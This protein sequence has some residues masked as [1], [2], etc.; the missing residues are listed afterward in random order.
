MV[1]ATATTTVLVL[2]GHS[3]NAEMMMERLT[4]LRKQCGNRVEFVFL[5]GPLALQ[6]GNWEL[7]ISTPRATFSTAIAPNQYLSRSW[8]SWIPEKEEAINLPES[9]EL[10]RDI[11]RT[12]T[13]DG[14]LGFS[15]GATMA[16]ILT[17]LLERPLIYPPFL[18]D[19][20]APHPPLK[21]CISVAGFKLKDPIANIIFAARYSTPTLHV[22]GKADTRIEAWKSR[23]L[24]KICTN[25]LIEEHDGGHLIP[26][27]GNW[28]R[29][30]TAFMQDPVEFTAPAHLTKL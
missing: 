22:I 4:A 24:A 6:S 26:S 2:H 21:F 5:D 9:L 19:G 27:D 17:A 16:A 8:W 12:R 1:N 15:Q 20:N 30:M 28:A 14:V 13:F 10:I 3:Q 7:F 11:L 25:A 23:N 18:I 29:F